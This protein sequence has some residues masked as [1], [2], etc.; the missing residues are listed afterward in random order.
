MTGIGRGRPSFS[1]LKPI[2]KI[3]ID[4]DRRTDLLCRRFSLAGCV[5]AHTHTEATIARAEAFVGLHEA[6]PKEGGCKNAE[7]RAGERIRPSGV[8]SGVR[9]RKVAE[10]SMTNEAASPGAKKRHHGT[11]Y[12]SGP[13]KREQRESHRRV[14][15][16]EGHHHLSHDILV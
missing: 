14:S 2:V 11:C 8:C 5:D 6:A 9:G 13:K 4:P 16:A 3:Q 7:D 12:T 15:T 1:T 10:K